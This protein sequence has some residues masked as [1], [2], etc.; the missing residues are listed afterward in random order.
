MEENPNFEFPEI[1][2]TPL[3]W[4]SGGYI[5]IPRLFGGFTYFLEDVDN[6][7][8]FYAEQS[9]RI[10]YD[11]DGYIYFEI[12]KNG[13]RTIDGEER[14]AVCIKFGELAKT[15]HKKLLH[16]L[17]ELNNEIGE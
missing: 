9:S 2:E 16:R 3:G 13:S 7:L 11:S 8:V 5:T 12:T 1:T 15:A 4:E 14:K 6:K 17:G 10:D